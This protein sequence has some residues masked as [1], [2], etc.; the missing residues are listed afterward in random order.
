MNSGLI[1]EMLKRQLRHAKI[2]AIEAVRW[3]RIELQLNILGRG[4]TAI[5]ASTICQNRKRKYYQVIANAS[6]Q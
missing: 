4:L 1:P 2:T 5:N 3:L 6:L